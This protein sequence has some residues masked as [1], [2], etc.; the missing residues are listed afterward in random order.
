MRSDT[1]SLD[2]AVII[3]NYRTAALTVESIRSLQAERSAPGLRIRVTVVDNASGDLPAI[4][5]AIAANGW[6]SWVTAVEAPKNGGFAYGNN[7]GIQHACLDGA[8]H[9][10]YLLN[11]DAQIRP[12]AIGSLV[13]FLEAHPE[14]GIAGSQIENTDGSEWP[15]AFRFP[16]LLSELSQ[17]LDLGVV[18]RL[19]R[20]WSV[21]RKMGDVAES[22]DWVS[23]AAMFIRPAVLAAVGGM[24]ENYFLYFEETDLCYRAKRAGFSTWYVPASRVVHLKGQS[25]GMSRFH[26]KRLP[27]Y[28]F[29]SRRRYFATAYGIRRA[30]LIDIVALLAGSVGSLKRKLLRQTYGVPHFTGDLLRNSLLRPRNVRFAPPCAPVPALI[31]RTGSNLHG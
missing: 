9:Y 7:L 18:I 8:P 24:D 4:A 10:I 25:T 12:G 30:V 21:A 29:E 22:V 27:T 2:I 19:L 1:D 23:G 20:T 16:S 17:G 5:D 13:D 28:W 15:I 14:V 3:V 6:S 26:P 11:P 31:S